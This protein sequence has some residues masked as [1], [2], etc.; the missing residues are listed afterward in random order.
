[1]S[2]VATCNC[3]LERISSNNVDFFNKDRTIFDYV[4]VIQCAYVRV[5]IINT[6]LPDGIIDE[7][8]KYYRVITP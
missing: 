2:P 4:H 8:A 5:H 1:M 3:I 6:A 7:I